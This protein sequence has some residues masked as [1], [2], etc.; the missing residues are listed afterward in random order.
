M[1]VE[2]KTY[3]LKDFILLGRKHALEDLPRQTGQIISELEP[4]IS[5][6]RLKKI[7]TYYYYGCR[8]GIIEQALKNTHIKV[9]FDIKTNNLIHLENGNE[10]SLISRKANKMMLKKSNLTAKHVLEKK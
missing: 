9:E 6:K 4:L 2:Y 5:I 8:L 10:S 1:K 7:L 3:K